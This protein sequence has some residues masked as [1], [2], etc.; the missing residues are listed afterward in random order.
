M[1]LLIEGKMFEGLR[2]ATRKLFGGLLSG[3]VKKV[4]IPTTT[5]NAKNATDAIK[6][7]VSALED[8]DDYLDDNP[9]IEAELMAR[10]KNT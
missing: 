8:I 1:S 2:S 10:L 7:I 3:K 6:Q 5:K 4:T 9:E